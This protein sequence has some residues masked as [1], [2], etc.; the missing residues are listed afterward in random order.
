VI[1]CVVEWVGE[2]AIG[3]GTVG[4]CAAGFLSLFISS[5]ALQ[6]LA[7]CRFIKLGYKR[8]G[9]ATSLPGLHYGVPVTN[10]HNHFIYMITSHSFDNGLECAGVKLCKLTFLS[11]CLF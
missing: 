1:L 11:L 10:N 2:R 8:L 6:K 4:G 9:L 5:L 3:V 7:P